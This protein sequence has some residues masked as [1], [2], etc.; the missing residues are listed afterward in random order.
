MPF[1]STARWIAAASSPR[2]TGWKAANCS[3][4]ARP[5]T[6]TPLNTLGDKTARIDHLPGTLNS[7]EYGRTLPKP[8]VSAIQA[9][10]IATRGKLHS[11][12]HDALNAF[13]Q[14]VRGAL[15]KPSL[16]QNTA[17]TLTAVFGRALESA[18]D[19]PDQIAQLQAD[20]NRLIQVDVAS[21]D[22]VRL[23]ANDYA[24][25]LQTALG[26]GRPIITPATPKLSRADR[27]GANNV[28]VGNLH[29]SLVGT[30]NSKGTPIGTEID[31]LDETGGVVGQTSTTTGG[32]YTITPAAILGYGSHTF[33]VRAVDSAGDFSDPSGPIT[34]TIVPNGTHGHP[35][36]PLASTSTAQ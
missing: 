29:P 12:S 26:I 5:A 35:K 24:V 6:P 3:R 21:K 4:S 18:G 32:K 14:Q 9:D 15:S 27:G 36:G 22:P 7:I 2:P 30:Y 1:G 28:V 17:V 11:P 23:A 31:L 13:N 19:T 10:I 25:I 34:I 16:S 20:T 33:R 8:I